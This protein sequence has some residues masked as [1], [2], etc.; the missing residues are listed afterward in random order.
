[1]KFEF[2]EYFYLSGT[3][4]SGYL[5]YR[6]ESSDTTL[7]FKGTELANT[8]KIIVEGTQTKN[9][10]GITIWVDYQEVDVDSIEYQQ[11]LLSR[12]KGITEERAKEIFKEHGFSSVK[13]LVKYVK[14]GNKIKGIGEK[15]AKAI[16][17]AVEKAVEYEK[18]IKLAFLIGNGRIAKKLAEKISSLEELYETPYALLKSCGMGFLK[19]DE[20]A[21]KKLN[22]SLDNEERNKYLVEYKFKQFNTKQ[23]NYIDMGEFREYLMKDVDIH[24]Y[25]DDY[26]TNNE[27]IV[28]DKERV[29]LKDIYEAETQTPE[30][31][32]MLNTK[33]Y[34]SCDI[35]ST[36]EQYQK[37][38]DIQL[39]ETQIEAVEKCS[40][41]NVSILT[42]GAGTGKSTITR[43]II[44][45]LEAEGLN[46][47]LLAPTGRASVRMSECTNR[48]SRTIHS[49]VW[50]VLG[51]LESKSMNAYDIEYMLASNFGLKCRRET[52][53]LVDEFSMV[54][55]KLFYQLLYTISKLNDEFGYKITGI[56]VI[57]DPFQ[58][59]SVGCGR[60]L[61]DMIQ[62]KKFNHVH[63]TKTF[64]Q[65]SGSLIIEN[66]NKVR[67]GKVIDFVKEKDFYVNIYNIQN[68]NSIY[69]LFKARFENIQDFYRSFQICSPLNAA[70]DAIN[71]LYKVD[72]DKKFS[73]GDKVINIR[74][75]RDYG[76]SN[77]DMGI[78]EALGYDLDKNYF[79]TVLFYDYEETK[80]ITFSSTETL[81]LA[82]CCTIH[83]LQG[84]EFKTVVVVLDRQ[85]KLLESKMFYT[86]ITRA[87]QN[88]CIL[89]IDK[90]TV[91]N[92][93]TNNNDWM[94]KTYFKQRL[95]ES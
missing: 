65:Q 6:S 28:P 70:C 82:Y 4:E 30:L 26:I 59:P 50:F 32:N 40:Q 38:N 5:F 7:A 14:D 51:A 34:F 10:Y 73:V 11:V 42:G 85:S 20:L 8:G 92:A 91:V 87:K 2:E 58:L 69:N 93:C 62:S 64:R 39:D 79:I 77:G 1:M 27:L 60:V 81:K 84:S 71:N 45:V 90:A 76:I 12:T 13:E 61:H 19:S 17:E 83:K 21:R 35:T 3:S 75:D 56:T 37:F 36:L 22:I 55:Q 49:F 43:G 29:Y 9:N 74:N 18:E 78:V 48:K 72:K 94:R 46:C 95:I 67:D 44:A 15:K 33:H 88:C 86:G 23:S 47:L 63:L 24:C 66:A 57:G 68:L 31:L 41:F 54:D 80:R 53:V 89:T 16:E 25:V 52:R